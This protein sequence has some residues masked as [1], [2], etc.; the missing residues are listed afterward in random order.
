[1]TKTL[2]LPTQALHD[3]LE[4]PPS[5]GGWQIRSRFPSPPRELPI[6]RDDSASKYSH[7][8]TPQSHPGTP[9]KAL[10]NPLPVLRH[11]PDPFAAMEL[12]SAARTCRKTILRAFPQDRA[13]VESHTTAIGPGWHAGQSRWL[14]TDPG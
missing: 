8:S 1:M 7:E 9:R 14:R 11:P 4:C 2:R 13:Q 6:R 12:L 10:S 5:A 3:C